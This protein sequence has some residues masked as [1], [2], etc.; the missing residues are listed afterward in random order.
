MIHK[1][2]WSSWEV[3]VILVRFQWKFTIFSRFSKNPKISNLIKIPL[4]GAELFHADRHDELIVAFVKFTNAHKNRPCSPSQTV[5]VR[6]LG[7]PG[8]IGEGKEVNRVIISYRKIITS[9]ANPPN[10]TQ[11]ISTR[12]ERKNTN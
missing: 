4:F 2:Y 6:Y 12:V 5:S 11:H 10:C 3:P 8:L 9:S 1:V 7:T